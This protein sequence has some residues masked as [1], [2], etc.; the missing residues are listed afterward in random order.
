MHDDLVPSSEEENSS[1]V[2]VKNWDFAIVLRTLALEHS[3]HKSMHRNIVL[4]VTAIPEEI[5]RNIYF[6][7]SSLQD[8]WIIQL[9]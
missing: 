4:K 2:K 7:G 3:R 1:T 9:I 6:Y 5:I 8:R